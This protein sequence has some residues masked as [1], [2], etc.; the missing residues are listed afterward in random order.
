MPKNEKRRSYDVE[1]EIRGKTYTGKRV[2]EGDRLMRQ[3]VYFGELFK[4]DGRTYENEGAEMILR[5]K[6]I[7]AEIIGE[8]NR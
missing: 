2:I 8:H 3:T 5:A 7:L 6:I 1:I 4:H